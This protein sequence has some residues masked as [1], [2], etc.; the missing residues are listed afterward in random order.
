MAFTAERL[1]SQAVIWAQHWH[2]CQAK[3]LLHAPQPQSTGQGQ[4]YMDL[5]QRQEPVGESSKLLRPSFAF[6]STNMV[7]VNP[8]RWGIPSQMGRLGPSFVITGGNPVRNASHKLERCV[9]KNPCFLSFLILKTWSFCI[10]LLHDFSRYLWSSKENP[11]R[12]YYIMKNEITIVLC[13]FYEY[14]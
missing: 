11:S 14:S 10:G 3:W 9:S 1:C 6:M 8:H 13:L 4:S 2:C 7:R 12:S 5:Q